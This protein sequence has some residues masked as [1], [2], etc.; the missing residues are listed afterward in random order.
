M[1]K[2]LGWNFDSGAD[3]KA[4]SRGNSLL[5]MLIAALPVLLPVLA[6]LVAWAFGW[7]FLQ[8]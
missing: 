7:K 5:P 4:A 8:F 1:T 2:D 3:H 6:V